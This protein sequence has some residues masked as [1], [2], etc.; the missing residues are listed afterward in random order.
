MFKFNCNVFRSNCASLSKQFNQVRSTCVV[1][2]DLCQESLPRTLATGEHSHCEDKHD[3]PCHSH[4]CADGQHKLMPSHTCHSPSDNHVHHHN[5]EHGLVY[6]KRVRSLLLLNALFSPA[7][8]GSNSCSSSSFS[9]GWNSCADQ[10]RHYAK[11]AS[12]KEKGKVKNANLPKVQLTDTEINS[13]IEIEALR[14]SISEVINSLKNDFIS[15]INVRMGRNIDDLKIQYDGQKFQL[16]QLA[17]ISRKNENLICI[18][19][20][21]C[22]GIYKYF[23]K[24]YGF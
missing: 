21:N 18:N 8:A 2:H 1:Y 7:S 16:K 20:V 4:E 17:Q 23:F 12:H 6:S 9:C 11:K 13:V 3:L 5:H 14:D 15:H 19:L 22:S 24:S 10:V